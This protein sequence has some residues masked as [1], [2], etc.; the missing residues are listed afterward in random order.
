MRVNS[1]DQSFP[2]SEL[3][4]AGY[5]HFYTLSWWVYLGLNH[6]PQNQYWVQ[7]YGFSI[8][9]CRCLTDVWPWGICGHFCW[10]LTP[11]SELTQILSEWERLV[12]QIPSA[13]QSQGKHLVL[14][15]YW[16]LNAL[17]PTLHLNS[18]GVFQDNYKNC[19]VENSSRKSISYCL[20]QLPPLY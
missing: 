16:I 7:A 3:D 4:N 11:C 9:L 12:S 2:S 18:T 20:L 1:G 5:R 13:Y 15:I 10:L 6:F 17:Q 14:C 8:T 19:A